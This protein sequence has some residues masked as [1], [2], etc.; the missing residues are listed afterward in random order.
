[1]VRPIPNGRSTRSEEGRMNDELD[2]HVHDE[3]ALDE[4]E[5]MA[6]LMIATS[7]ASGP[8]P[9]QQVDEI[10]GIEND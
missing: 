1:M 10:L 7:E 4:I 6:N 2:V 5:M 9:Q 3:D 8:L